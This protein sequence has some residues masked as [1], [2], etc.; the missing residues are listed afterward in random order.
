MLGEWGNF[1]VF[2]YAC[3]ARAKRME[4]QEVNFACIARVVR[5]GG[6]LIAIVARLSAIPG[7][8]TT[9]AF[10]ATGVSYLLPDCQYS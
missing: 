1:T 5:E 8:L 6:F 3:T 2:K 10:A 9:P 7:H 4:E